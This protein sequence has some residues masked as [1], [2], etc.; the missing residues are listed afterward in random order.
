[1]RIVQFCLKSESLSG[2]NKISKNHP[3]KVGIQVDG[4]FGHI[5]DINA[6]DTISPFQIKNTLDLIS[7]WETK[8]GF[9]EEIHR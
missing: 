9:K 5:I 6:Y 8:Q 2:D 3:T 4:E 7:A 1:M